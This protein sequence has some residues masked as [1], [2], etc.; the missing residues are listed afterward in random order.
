MTQEKLDQL[1]EKSEKLKDR[2][3]DLS[4][5]YQLLRATTNFTECQTLANQIHEDLVEEQQPASTK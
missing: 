5:K 3:R 4:G 1:I 2:L